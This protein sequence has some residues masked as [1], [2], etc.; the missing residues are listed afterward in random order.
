M[1]EFL[2][3]FDMYFHPLCDLN[4]KFIENE[5]ILNRTKIKV[6]TYNVFLRPPPVKNNENDWKD[7]R[8]ADIIKLLD[9]FDIICF[10]EMFATF[11]NRRQEL[12]KYA[13]K[14]G[15]FFYSCSPSP[16]FFSKFLVD[17]GLLILSRFPIVE[18]EYKPFHY[19]V[20]SDSLANKGVLFAKIRIKNSYL[21][22]FNTHLQASYFGSSEYH[23]TIS[24]KTRLDHLDELVAYI[25]EVLTEQTEN[26]PD[27]NF[28]CLLVGDFNA[29]AHNYE[30]KKKE[31]NL[32]FVT[33]D[34]YK[35]LLEK[36]NQISQ[37]TDIIKTALKFS[38]YT[39][40]YNG[41]RLKHYDRVLT[42][43][44]DV[45]SMQTLDYM[46]EI[47][48]VKGNESFIM[49]NTHLDKQNEYKESNLETQNNLEERLINKNNLKDSVLSISE[50]Q[51]QEENHTI[52]EIVDAVQSKN[53]LPSFML[54][55]VS[56][57]LVVDYDSPRVEHFLISGK[58]YQQLSDHFGLSLDLKLEDILD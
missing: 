51:K 20:L 30:T 8:L 53:K 12:I 49:R 50:S 10:Q 16:S 48:V 56:Q 13:N 9:G 34:E 55:N 32:S 1:D 52:M 47:K 36:L 2:N 27:D 15:L 5:K 41:E 54:R 11:N 35:S 23:W 58:P 21:L 28:T 25:K 29:D 43:K 26:N 6:L 40:G 19:A 37:C 4:E 46:F 33:V 38:P 45:G 14:S 17:G 7:E 24:V 42:A 3:K 39:F 22:L 57:K 44:E 31:I 18:S